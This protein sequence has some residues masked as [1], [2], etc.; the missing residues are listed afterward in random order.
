MSEAGLLLSSPQNA[1]NPSTISFRPFN[2][3]SAGS[4][5]N[6]QLPRGEVVTLLAAGVGWLAAATNKMNLRVISPGGVQTAIVSLPGVPVSIAGHGARLLIAYSTNM[7]FEGHAH[8]RFQYLDMESKS[9]L[10]HDEV[11]ALSPTSS[12]QWF[13]FTSEGMPASYDSAGVVRVATKDFGW[14]WTPVGDLSSTLSS[15]VDKYYIVSVSL[16]KGVKAVYCKGGRAPPVLPKPSPSTF[17]LSPPV[18][19]T[20]SA[21]DEAKL[22]IL[23]TVTSHCEHLRDEETENGDKLWEASSV[24]ADMARVRLFA[25][26][27]QDDKGVKAVDLA[28]GLHHSRSIEGCANIARQTGRAQVADRIDM[29][30]DLRRQEEEDNESETDDIESQE[31]DLGRGRGLAAPEPTQEMAFSDDDNDNVL[32][33]DGES[34]SLKRTRDSAEVDLGSPSATRA[35]RANPFLSV[36]SQASPRKSLLDRISNSTPE[37]PS[38]N[39]NVGPKAAFGRRLEF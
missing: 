36:P 27:C 31:I 23:E 1:T 28:Q 4:D 30:A 34:N 5:W 14:T 11:L 20:A 18:I 19:Q 22:L 8:L 25:A 37:K 32:S 7:S 33:S 21:Q 16:E 35:V 2:A 29:L 39:T 13:G 10:N 3:W 26:A 9:K 38:A 17:E 24:A 15:V 6:I 12:L